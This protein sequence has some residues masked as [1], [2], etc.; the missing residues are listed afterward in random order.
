MGAG[1]CGAPSLEPG[2]RA[3]YVASFPEEDGKDGEAEDSV[4]VEEDGAVRGAGDEPEESGA[5]FCGEKEKQDDVGPRV[6]HFRCAFRLVRGLGGG[7]LAWW[8]LFGYAG[9]RGLVL[10]G[11]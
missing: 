3:E 4:E 7:I 11:G 8:I 1:L 9:G 10:W 6:W 2:E 5:Q